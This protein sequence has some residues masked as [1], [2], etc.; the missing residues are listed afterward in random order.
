MTPSRLRARA[1][2]D[3]TLEGDS[4]DEHRQYNTGVSLAARRTGR[5]QV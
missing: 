1:R 5:L 3:S 2:R 4:Q